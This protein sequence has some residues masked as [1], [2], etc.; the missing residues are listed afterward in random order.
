MIWV[1]QGASSRDSQKVMPVEYWEAVR[2]F[3]DC[4]VAEGRRTSCFMASRLLGEDVRD[5]MAS[6]D[7]HLSV[8]FTGRL[9]IGSNLL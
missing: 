1:L 5:P 7:E 6:L 8:F 2:D 3:A 4:Q 9:Q